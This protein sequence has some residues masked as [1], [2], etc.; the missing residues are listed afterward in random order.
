[1]KKNIRDHG[2]PDMGEKPTGTPK[3][4]VIEDKNA[5]CP[6]CGCQLMEVS[7]EM[8][9]RLLKAGKGTGTYLGCPACPFASPMVTVSG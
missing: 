5:V 6:N 4:K 7:V 1:V 9:S 3:A 8:S 2:Y